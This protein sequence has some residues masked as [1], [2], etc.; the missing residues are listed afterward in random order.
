M[1]SV[2]PAGRG[3]GNRPN[4]GIRIVLIP[5]RI[6]LS[7]LMPIKIWIQIRIGVKTM[8]IHLRILP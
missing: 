8:P 3:I 4:I 1:K 5:I 7:I 6:L 2:K